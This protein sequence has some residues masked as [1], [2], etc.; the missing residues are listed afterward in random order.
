MISR[1]AGTGIV[2]HPA[3]E[4]LAGTPRA[5]LKRPSRSMTAGNA[6]TRPAAVKVSISGRGSNS[7]KGPKHTQ[8][9][10]P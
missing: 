2:P 5:I 3:D 4:V 6:T 1:F 7:P 9:A 8:R 10:D